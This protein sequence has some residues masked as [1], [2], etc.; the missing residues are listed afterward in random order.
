MTTTDIRTDI[1]VD[2]HPGVL[3]QYSD[4]LNQDGTMGP[5][6]LNDGLGALTEIYSTL[7]KLIDAQVAWDAAAPKATRM[8]AGRATEVALPSTEL[9]T[10]AERAFTNSAKIV[11]Q[12]TTALNRH[13]NALE[14]RVA[15]ALTD[16]YS[17]TPLGAEIRGYV[18]GL[19]DGQRL[20]FVR[21]LIVTQ[22]KADVA[23]ILDAPSY[24][25]GLTDDVHASVRDMAADTFATVDHRQ[26]LSTREV[27]ARVERASGTLLLAFTKV[28]ANKHS[29]ASKAGNAIRALG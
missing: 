22:K 27:L 21:S 12:R 8:V 26:L 7:G 25:S 11:D 6:A 9:I 29:P 4:V 18:R 15:S 16:P 24:L 2:I 19:K 13:V 17:K 10:A 5:H 20:D 28:I 14:T 1:P 3:S 23:A